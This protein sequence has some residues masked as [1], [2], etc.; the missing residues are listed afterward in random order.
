[1]PP[2]P[3]KRIVAPPSSA[4]TPADARIA[5]LRKKATWTPDEQVELLRLLLE[6]YVA[7]GPAGP[8]P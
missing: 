8:T 2:T 1:M 4:H 5:V 7:R 6:D 3:R